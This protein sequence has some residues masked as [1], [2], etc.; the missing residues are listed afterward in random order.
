[1]SKATP[2]SRP[3]LTAKQELFNALCFAA[4]HDSDRVTFVAH[5]NTKIGDDGLHLT[6]RGASIVAGNTGRHV[7]GLFWQKQR[8][9]GH[10]RPRHQQANR[11]TDTDNRRRPRH[12][13]ANRPTDT[14]NRRRPRHQQAN[15]LNDTDNRR[16]PSRR[17]SLPQQ[18]QPPRNHRHYQPPGNRYKDRFATGGSLRLQ[19]RQPERR[20]HYWR[21]DSQ[22][23]GATTGD[24]TAREEGS[25][26]ERRRT[27]RRGHYWRDDGQGSQRRGATTGEATDRAA[28]GDRGNATT[29]DGAATTTTT[30]GTTS[31]VHIN[32]STAGTGKCDD[33]GSSHG[34]CYGPFAELIHFCFTKT[35]E[36]CS[37][38]SWP[39]RARQLPCLTPLV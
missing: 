2:T 15:R 9:R 38:Q 1:M 23:G 37:Q 4:L 18:Q 12:Q 6:L 31:P 29:H 35:G 7:A 17:T 19:H 26:L 10:R 5:Y 27:E 30:G 16:G 8:S 34:C 14:D 3:D 32:N 21:Q 25:L 13:Q 22:R 28:S 11:P 39:A 20:G 33:L 24:R 36:L